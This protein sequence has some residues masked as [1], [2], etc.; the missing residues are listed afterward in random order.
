MYVLNCFLIIRIVFVRVIS[1]S[2]VKDLAVNYVSAGITTISVFDVLWLRWT[3]LRCRLTSHLHT[4]LRHG[5]RYCQI[6][7]VAWSLWSGHV[8][9]A[10][11]DSASTSCFVMEKLCRQLNLETKQV[12]RSLFGID[13]VTSGVNKTCSIT[14]V[15]RSSAN[16]SGQVKSTSPS[17]DNEQSGFPARMVRNWTRCCW[18]STSVVTSNFCNKFS[19]LQCVVDGAKNVYFKKCT[20]TETDARV[21]VDGFIPCF[22]L[23]GG[24]R[25]RRCGGATWRGGHTNETHIFSFNRFNLT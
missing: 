4:A 13:N 12:D 21:V 11:F 1:R 3:T 5:M 10:V 23:V 14:S 9:R 25:P 17:C 7:K 2:I 15:L 18:L 22:A 8:V 6:S 19:Q 20:F 24:R 16:T